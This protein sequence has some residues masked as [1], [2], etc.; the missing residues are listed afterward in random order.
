MSKEYLIKNAKG[1][2]NKQLLQADLPLL[3][4]SSIK[5]LP[6]SIERAPFP[7]KE[8]MPLKMI[9]KMPKM[10]SAMTS[11]FTS[12]KLIK[13]LEVKE[14]SQQIDQLGVDEAIQ[15]LKDSGIDQ[16]GYVEIDEG[17]V[18]K[19]LAVPYKHVIIFTAR[20][21]KE[22]ILTSPSMRSQVEVGRIYGQTGRAANRL[23]KYLTG[24]GY[25]AMPSHSLGGV[26]DYTKLARRAGLGE[27]GRHGLLIEPTSGPNH[28]L[29]AV[30]TNIDNLGV[31]F[32]QT[33]DHEWIKDFCAKCGKCRRECPGDAIKDRATMNENGYIT[34]IDHKK[35]EKYF[36]EQF[37]CNICV[38]K[39]PFTTVGY[40]KIKSGIFI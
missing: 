19:H 39:C 28:R 34:T 8:K 13:K 22:D 2:L 6:T 26:I 15:L 7:G 37:G 17:D 16:S 20:Q 38:A 33:N 4:K 21:D 30:F 11:F 29:G 12:V 35:C 40:V 25:G 3:E 36:S 9:L 10:M 5:A 23:T 1:K 24:K 31:Y 32:D 14:S 18:F 27:I